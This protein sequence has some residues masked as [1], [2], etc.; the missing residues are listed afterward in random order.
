MVSL[1]SFRRRVVR[2][3]YKAGYRFLPRLLKPAA[4]G[5]AVLL[6]HSVEDGE[7]AWTNKLGHNVS[8]HRFEEHIRFLTEH[9]RVVPFS[10]LCRSEAAPDEIAITFDDGSAS[11]KKNVLPIIEK[12]RCPIKVYATLEN[13]AEINWLNKL[14]YLLNLLPA[15][16][17]IELTK[18][19]LGIALSRKP[20]IHDFVHHF[21]MEQTPV[22]LN[23]CFR[24]L[25]PPQMRRLYLSIEELR[26][27]AVHPLVEIGSHTRRHYPLPRLNA[28]QLRDEVIAAHRELNALLDDRVQGF[29]IP[30]GFR[31]HRTPE[32]VAAITA[33]DGVVVSAYGGRLD[34]QMCYSLPEVK[35]ISV[36]GNL[37]CL[38][39]LLSH[40][41]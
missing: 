4:S 24:K 34:W 35:R 28:E 33:I 10:H 36:G 6:Y 20:G 9:F 25:R 39:Y 19:A 16:E 17:Q 32:I 37:G 40:P 7:D 2:Q 31:T 1:R 5:P 3:A 30:F 15:A 41:G 12:Y 11:I 26:E 27:L 8:P 14:C 38:W 13:A 29:A 23:E 22:V 21:D 18:R